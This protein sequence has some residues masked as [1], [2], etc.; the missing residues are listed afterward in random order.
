MITPCPLSPLC[1]HL[2]ALDVFVSLSGVLA[3]DVVLHMPQQNTHND[4]RIGEYALLVWWCRLIRSVASPPVVEERGPSGGLPKGK[5]KATMQEPVAATLSRPPSPPKALGSDTAR[6]ADQAGP[7]RAASPA[8][9]DS[10]PTGNVAGT[11]PFEGLTEE[12]IFRL[13]TRP[14]DLEGVQDWGIPPEV[15]PDQSS[16]TLKVSSQAW[17][18]CKADAVG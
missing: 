12:E 18:P 5:G 14:D 11:D 16:D 9:V 7:S 3:S 2:I 8:I 17:K 15:D 6:A 10:G 4:P 1:T 13:V